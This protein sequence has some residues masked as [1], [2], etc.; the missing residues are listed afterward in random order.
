MDYASIALKTSITI[1]NFGTV[2]DVSR[3]GETIGQV[4]ALFITDSSELEEGLTE[5]D[6]A[7]LL[8]D[9]GVQLQNGDVLTNLGRVIRKINRVAPDRTTII[10]QEVEA[11]K[12]I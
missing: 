3:N 12:C 10:Y 11:I 1:K 9:N 5:I 6:S 2:S 7:T 8:I 4:S